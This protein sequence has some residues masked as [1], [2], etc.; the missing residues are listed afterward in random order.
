[1]QQIIE[2]YL[3][4]DSIENIHTYGSGLINHTWVIDT[5]DHTFILQRI[6]DEV[7]RNPALIDQNI[8]AVGAY[9][10]ANNPGYLFTVPVTNQS[11][12]TLTQTAEGYF[13]MFEFVANSKTFDVVKAPELAFEAA[14]QFGK[15]THILSGFPV[16]TL[17][18]TLPDFHNLSLRYRQFKMAIANAYA[19]RLE[20]SKSIIAALETHVNIVDYYEELLANPAFKKRVTHHDTKISNVLFDNDNKGIC[21]IDLDTLMPGYFISDVGDMMRTYLSEAGEE[22]TD[23]DKV[24]VREEYFTAIMNGYLSEMGGELSNEELDSF[25][26][27]GKFM[28]Y[29][30]SLRFITDYL[31]EDVY[32]GARYELH[33][34]NRAVNQLT[35]LESLLSK[36]EVLKQ[37]VYALQ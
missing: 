18:I 19:E 13:R 5:L 4:K 3:L 10:K 26:Y 15:L 23:F 16:D 14:K 1:M 22:E 36:E 31:N 30:Q 37:Q 25:V 32:Y 33:N 9:L 35:L 8:N 28:I 34:Y 2:K 11:H 20:K 24:F 17:K 6:N 29:M 27:A 7:F 21:V 12:E